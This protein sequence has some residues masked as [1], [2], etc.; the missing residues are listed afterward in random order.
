MI[1]DMSL[2]TKPVPNSCAHTNPLSVYAVVNDNG[3]SM[4][5][6]TL[7]SFVE[8]NRLV[9]RCIFYTIVTAIE[10][11]RH[12]QLQMSKSV[13]LVAP[14]LVDVPLVHASVKLEEKTQVSLSCLF[15]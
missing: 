10:I 12:E 13:S 6:N 14:T 3:F 4:R 8:A 11:M 15:S 9:R 7:S 1:M 2:K 5:V